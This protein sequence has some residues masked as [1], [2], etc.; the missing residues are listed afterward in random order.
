MVLES[1]KADTST[2]IPM[3]YRKKIV[4]IS[5]IRRGTIRKITAIQNSEKKGDYEDT[6]TTRI[7]AAYILNSYWKIRLFHWA[8]WRMMWDKYSDEELLAICEVCKKKVQVKPYCEIMI[9]QTGLKDTMKML[10]RTEIETVL[11]ERQLEQRD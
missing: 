1:L 11:Q 7:A 2:K 3:K 8:L 5:W 4:G 9:L 10:T 6:V